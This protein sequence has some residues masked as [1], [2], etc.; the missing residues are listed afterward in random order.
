MGVL[1]RFRKRS[2]PLAIT[3]MLLADVLAPFQVS[4]LTCAREMGR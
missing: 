4:A 1:V 3:A 2:L